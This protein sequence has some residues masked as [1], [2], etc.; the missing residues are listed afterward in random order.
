MNNEICF[1]H[2]KGRPFPL[3]GRYYANIFIHFEPIG[4]SLRH[5]AFHTAESNMNEKY[6]NAVAKRHGGHENEV[7]G[8]PPYIISGSEEGNLWK[9]KHPNDKRSAKPAKSQTGSNAIHAAA[10]KGDMSG[11]E[12]VVSILNHL[13]NETD[14]NGWTPLHEG[15]RA[16]HTDIVKLLVHHEADINALTKDGKSPLYIAAASNGK[17]HP[18]VS[19]FESLG[20]LSIGPEL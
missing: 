12:E 13:I 11:L 18:I 16:G 19:L 9:R 7:E 4:H 3:K 14:S 20:A 8:L 10:R 6:R 15:A 5:D 17:D 2:S 1:T